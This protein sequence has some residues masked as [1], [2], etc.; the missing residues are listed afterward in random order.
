MREIGIHYAHKGA[1][2]KV[3]SVDVCRATHEPLSLGLGE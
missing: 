2:A 1:R 3:E